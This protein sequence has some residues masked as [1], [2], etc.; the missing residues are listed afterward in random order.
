[1]RKAILLVA[2]LAACHPMSLKDRAHEIGAKVSAAG[3]SVVAAVRPTVTVALDS[4]AAALIKDQAHA[5]VEAKVGAAIPAQPIAVHRS[6]VHEQSVAAA[7]PAPAPI[8]VT[9]THVNAAP[10]TFF[11][12]QDGNH[13]TRY[14]TIDACNQAC[15]SLAQQRGMHGQA[16]ASCSCLQDAPGC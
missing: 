8:P 14:E 1:M 11:G 3:S 4:P 5:Y 12:L 9:V 7:A 6:I 16:N 10:K 2:A 15:T 13:C